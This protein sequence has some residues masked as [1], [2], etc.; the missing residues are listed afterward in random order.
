MKV[1][2]YNKIL[3]NTFIFVSLIFGQINNY[4]YKRQIN[5]VDSNWHKIIL[6]NDLFEK[7]E[8]NFNDLRIIGFTE[9]GDTIEVPYIINRTDARINTKEQRFSIINESKNSQGYFYTFEVP[10]MDY[11]NQIDLRFSK[12]NFDWRIRLEGSQ[13]LIDWFDIIENYRLLSINNKDV[14]F[15][16]S[17]IVFLKSKYKY[18]RLFVNSIE[19]PELVGANIFINEDEK[20]KLID[21][22]INSLEVLNNK[23]KKQTQINIKLNYKVPVSKIKIEIKDKEDY[24]RPVTIDYIIDSIKTEKGWRHNTKKI[25]SG[26]LNSFEKNIFSFEPTISNNFTIIINNFD[27]KSLEIDQVV[28][29]GPIYELIGRFDYKADYYLFYGNKK[30]IKPNYDLNHFINRIPEE[31]FNLS[32]GTEIIIQEEVNEEEN[33][34]VENK[35][36]LWL[37]ISSIVLLLGWFSIKMLKK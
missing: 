27:N 33:P 6:P 24:Y 16:Y 25:T 30:A 21:Y 31:L 5:G 2:T 9:K 13:N 3:I 29:Q 22:S 28:L 17:K 26:I 37:I 32:L 20:A 8:V 12:K 4:T 14:T 36:W 15:D 18:Y 10:K 11:V 23:Q 35:I 1:K 7:T 34:I 19:N